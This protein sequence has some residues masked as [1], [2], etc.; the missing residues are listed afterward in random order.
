MT[1]MSLSS[2]LKAAVKTLLADELLGVDDA[3]DEA[4]EDALG[5]KVLEPPPPIALT[6]VVEDECRGRPSLS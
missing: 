1:L 3:L 6:P 4:F 2:A 5:L